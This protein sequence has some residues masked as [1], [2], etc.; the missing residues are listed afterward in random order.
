MRWVKYKIWIGFI[1]ENWGV[2]THIATSVNR[3]SEIQFILLSQNSFWNG[4]RVSRACFGPKWTQLAPVE[5]GSRQIGPLIVNRPA[6]WAP[7]C[8]REQIRPLGT[9]CH[10]GKSWNLEMDNWAL[11]I[12]WNL[13]PTFEEGD[14][15]VNFRT[16][17]CPEPQEHPERLVSFMKGGHGA[18]K[19]SAYRDFLPSNPIHL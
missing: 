5:R 16:P 13:K 9:I 4:K 12:Y 8:H 10:P 14:R 2:Q 17:I 15:L 1:V 7:I 11:G 6:N 19:I 3:F 18:L